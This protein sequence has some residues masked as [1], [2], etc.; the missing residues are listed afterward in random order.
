MKVGSIS[1]NISYVS[2]VSGK[3]SAAGAK[4]A[5]A[6]QKS[7]GQSAGVSPH[8]GL[9]SAERAFFAKLFPDSISQINSHKT[10]SPNG[11]KAS[12]EPGQIINRK[13]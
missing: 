11:I 3:G 6:P 9:T 5:S 7:Q 2:A 10:Y 13:A 12:I 4:E 1:S 8:T